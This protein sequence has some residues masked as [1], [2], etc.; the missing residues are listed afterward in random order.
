MRNFAEEQRAKIRPESERTFV[1]PGDP[2][3]ETF[4]LRPSIPPDVMAVWDEV[5]PGTPSRDVF[6]AIDHI[7]TGSLHAEDRDRY[8]ALRANGDAEDVAN[9]GTLFEVVKWIIET[10]TSFPTPGA[11]PSGDGSSNP[12]NGASSTAAVPSP[13]SIQAPYL[14]DVSS[15]PATPG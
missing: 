7:V 3:D 1:L 5:G 11:S 4:V 10:E 14:S 8:L 13:V 15:A 9:L 6:A 2:Q 12:T